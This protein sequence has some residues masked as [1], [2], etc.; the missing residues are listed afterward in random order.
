MNNK[1]TLVISNNPLDEYSN[2]GKTI[3]S[4]FREYPKEQL[5]QLYFDSALP[6]TD[7]FDK[8]YQLTDMDMIRYRMKKTKKCGRVV[9]AK[10]ASNAAKK[11]NDTNKKKMHI[12][13]NS[14]T[15]LLR[16]FV[17]SS[18]WKK[19]GLIKWLDSIHPEIVFF[20]AGDS[21]FAYKICMY[22][23]KRYHAKLVVF[24]TDDYILP[25]KTMSVF[26]WLRRNYIFRHMKNAVSK[27]DVFMTIS[28]TMSKVYK[29]VF[30]K[31]SFVAVNM[32]ESLRNEDIAKQAVNEKVTL[33]Y[34]GGLH[35][36]RDKVLLELASQISRWNVANEKKAF[37]KIY[38]AQQIDKKQR[39]QLTIKGSSAFMGKLDQEGLVLQLNSADILV[40]VE[41]FDEKNIYDTKL[42][43]STKIP[44]YMSVGKPIM[45]IGPKGIASMEYLKDVAICVN[46]IKDL[47]SELERILSIDEKEKYGELALEKYKKNH[48]SEVNRKKFMDILSGL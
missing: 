7:R 27:S 32:T 22:I 2:N 23:V 42:S 12:K 37:L 46:N 30:S 26:W 40:H 16:E 35:L 6:G 8:Y 45:A 21:V 20:V 31:E 43:L 4:F 28:E 5:A 34:A 41:S 18:A 13:K 14:F 33:V 48:L 19:G 36:N 39:E 38:S 44:E 24:I 9:K 11:E 25:R 29:E 10:P 15:R 17:W 3:L 47:Y 1:K